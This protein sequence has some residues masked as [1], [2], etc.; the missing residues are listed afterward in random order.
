MDLT[1]AGIE[2]I[3]ASQGRL[4]RIRAPR[5]LGLWSLRIAVAQPRPSQSPLLLGDLKGWALPTPAGLH[6]DTMRVQGPNTAGVGDLIWAAT[7]AWAL[8]CTPCRQ[9]WLLAIRDGELQHRRLVRYF[10]QR[11]FMPRRELGAGLFD[12]PGRLQWGGAGLLMVGDCQAGLNR[13]AR[14]LTPSSASF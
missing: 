14:R 11:G 2:S 10:N 3:A 7:F 1:L 9:A 5:R 8:E 12:L 4:L 13:C 6:L